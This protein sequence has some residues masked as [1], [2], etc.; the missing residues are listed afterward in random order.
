MCCCGNLVASQGKLIHAKVEAEAMWA[1]GRGPL[2]GR[3]RDRLP[4]PAEQERMKP[5]G[6]I[7]GNVI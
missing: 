4:H 5:E 2:S 6:Q 3:L 1:L 7:F